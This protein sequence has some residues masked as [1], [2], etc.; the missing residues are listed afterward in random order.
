MIPS[1]LAAEV[2]G[3][4][5]DILSTGFGPSNLAL[6]NVVKDFLDDS[7]NLLKG[8]YLSVDLSFQRAPEGGEPFPD[9]PGVSGCDSRP[10][11]TSALTPTSS[12]RPIYDNFTPAVA[13]RDLVLVLDAFLGE[14]IQR[15]EGRPISEIGQAATTTANTAPRPRRWSACPTLCMQTG[16]PAVKCRPG[17]TRAPCSGADVRVTRTTARARQSMPPRYCRHRQ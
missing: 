10:V 2:S 7:D 4:L 8:P 13:I 12:N 16:F 6:S 14:C 3:A 11:P 9:N 5:R 17:A 1:S 15:F